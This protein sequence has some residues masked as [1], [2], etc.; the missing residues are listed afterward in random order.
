M[1]VLLFVLGH[2]CSGKTT[3][4]EEFIKNKIAKKE[5][6]SILDKDTIGDK[7]GRKIL[8]LMCL[9]QEDRDSPEF[10]K[11]VRDIEYQACLDV[12]REQLKNGISVVTP[13]PWTK[14]LKEGFIL[15]KVAMSL[16]DDVEVRH[17][18]LDVP[19]N[20]IK[21]RMIKRNHPRDEWKLNNWDIFKQ[22][23]VKP[24]IVDEQ[25]ILSIDDLDFSKVIDKVNSNF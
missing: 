19:E 24:S 22:T 2:S 16:P 21:E 4:A 8:S 3:I 15:D 17:V 14:E 18:F 1:P 20:I 12:I 25:N 10:K 23:L 5:C 6:W 13:G 7:F 11:H 9:P